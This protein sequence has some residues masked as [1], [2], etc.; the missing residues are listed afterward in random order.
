MTSSLFKEWFEKKVLSNLPPKSVI[1]MDNAT[2]HSEQIRKIPGVASTK[3]QISDF[4]YNNDLYFEETYTKKKEMLEVL[5]TKVFEKQFVIDELVKRDG[6]NVLRL[7]PYYCVFNP[8]ESIWS[9]LKESLRRNNCCPKFSSESVSHV[10]EEI[11]KISPTLL[12]NCLSH[13]IKTEDHYRTLTSHIKPIIIT[14]DNDSSEDDS[15]SDIEL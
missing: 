14:L 8:I 15:D 10:V 5:H 3:K 6:H 13:V 4:L 9:Q 11:K 12:Q 7:P 2:Y 1:V